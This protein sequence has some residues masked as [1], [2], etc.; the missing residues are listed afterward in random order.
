MT[1]R[2]RVSGVYAGKKIAIYA[3]DTLIYSR[4]KKVMAPGE[5]ETV[6]LKCK[7]LLD[8]PEAEKI[9]VKLEDA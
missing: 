1:L 5:M 2:F 8:S 4:K 6:Q 7:A 9:L 3:G